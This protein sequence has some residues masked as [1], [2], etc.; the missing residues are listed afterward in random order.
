MEEAT[1][2]RPRAE[3]HT[4]CVQ[5][6]KVRAGRF[7]LWEHPNTARRW[8]TKAF[9]GLMATH[10]VYFLISV[11]ADPTCGWTRIEQETDQSGDQRI[12]HVKVAE[13]VYR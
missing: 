4:D 5:Q 3:L 7:A 2:R 1:A 6:K 9:Q 10:W 13:D 12:V 11:N 8:D